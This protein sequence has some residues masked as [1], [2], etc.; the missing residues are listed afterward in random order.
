MHQHLE[1]DDNTAVLTDALQRL[2]LLEPHQDAHWIPLAGGVSS[3]IWRVEWP[4]TT[5]C[6]KRARPKLAVAAEWLAPVERNSSEV[7]W[8]ELAHGICPGSVPRVLGHCPEL[9]L[10]VMEY[11]DPKQ[12]PVWKNELAAGRVDEDFAAR[13][14]GVLGE[15]HAE[16]AECPGLADRF[17]TDEMFASLRISPYLEATALVHP[18]L[19]PRLDALAQR[20]TSTKLALVHGDISPKNVLV[21]PD[22]PVILDAECAWYG[23]PAFDV[24]FCL[25]HLLLK[26]RW[27]TAE[28]K[29]LLRSFDAFAAAH[30]LHVNWEPAREL[31]ARVATL[32]PA[33]LLARVDGKSPVEYLTHEDDR[34][35]VREVAR[36]LLMDRHDE[37]AVVREIWRRSLSR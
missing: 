35:S 13:L 30:A 25:T 8:L 27:V 4:G 1:T 33:L 32:L 7:A 34:N 9:H 19:A 37:L 22:E 23:D 3:D 6:V 2:G 17:G 24:A 18:E 21:G 10:F 14:G 26:C 31:E 15:I 11:I 28:R 5:L 36:E 20:T 29:R 16:T 12:S